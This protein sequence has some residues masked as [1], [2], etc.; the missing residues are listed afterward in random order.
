VSAPV[1]RF[2][3]V[4]IGCAAGTGE[5]RDDALLGRLREEAAAAVK[6]IDVPG[7]CARVAHPVSGH[8]P[9]EPGTGYDALLA[10]GLMNGVR[11]GGLAAVLD[12]AVP[13]DVDA[14]V[15]VE[16]LAGFGARHADVIDAAASIAVVGTDFVILDGTAPVQLF[17]FMRRN[18]ALT[19]AEFTDI[20]RDQH[21]K[22]AQFTP[23]LSGY[24][25]LHVDP[26]R[27]AAAGATTGIGTVD[28]DGVALE[29]FADADAFVTATSAPP[30]FLDQAKASE[31]RFN[32]L[33]RV[34]AV[35]TTVDDIVRADPV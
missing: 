28:V 30:E 20:W 26:E 8:A 2:T 9:G 6:L 4:L 12:V 16:A 10:D 21:T 24:R 31:A 35:L 17:Y 32:D 5:G 14:S 11:L 1:A 19:P 27:S 18:P 34:T 29:W 23:A 3:R 25:Q 33:G 13:H 7:A 22:I 15:P